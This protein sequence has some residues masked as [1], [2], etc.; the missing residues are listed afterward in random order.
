MKDQRVESQKF[1]ANAQLTIFASLLTMASKSGAHDLQKE[2]DR[3]L[4][5]TSLVIEY[6]D[7]QIEKIAE[8]T[9]LREAAMLKAVQ[10]APPHPFNVRMSIDTKKLKEKEQKLIDDAMKNLKGM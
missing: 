1:V 8:E 6:E 5:T 3:I 2:I 10:D 9:R 4:Q 7:M